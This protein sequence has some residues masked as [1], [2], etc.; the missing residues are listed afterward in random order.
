MVAQTTKLTVTV[1]PELK[2]IAS[3]VARE[4][5]TSRSKVVAQC[6]EELA[7]SRKE[8]LMIKYY[9][10]MAKEHR[11]FAKKSAKVIQEIASSWGD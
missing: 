1:S 4:M 6:L 8:K 7:R 10:D 3:Q 9:K 2:E 11:D 5:K